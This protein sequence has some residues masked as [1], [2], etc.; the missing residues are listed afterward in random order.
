MAKKR[1]VRPGSAVDFA[2][3]RADAVRR[4][5]ERSQARE[6]YKEKAWVELYEKTC[7][8]VRA[9]LAEFG[10]LGF[11][12]LTMTSVH[13]GCEIALAKEGLQVR[14]RVDGTD[15]QRFPRALDISWDLGDGN[16]LDRHVRIFTA[17]ALVR[18][19]ALSKF[20]K[21]F[22]YWMGNRI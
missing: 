19:D 17:K 3:K 11:E 10:E 5:H 6:D 21:S 1:L 13:L 20:E 4:A 8:K 9:I 16:G 7:V 22:G 15:H 14:V 12:V 18:I 2:L